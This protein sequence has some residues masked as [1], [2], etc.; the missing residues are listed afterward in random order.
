MLEL[1][2]ARGVQGYGGGLIIGGTLGLVSRVFQPQQRTR[3]LALYQGTWSLCS[4]IG[5]FFGGAFAEIGWGRGAFWTSLPF[6]LGFCAM[7]WWEVPKGLT[8]TGS[9]FPLVR[10]GL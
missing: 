7:A 6:I 9:G 5:P 2:L 1:I 3:V 8:Q 4:L 10:I